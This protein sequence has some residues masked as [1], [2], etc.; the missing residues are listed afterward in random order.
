MCMYQNQNRLKEMVY[1]WP[2]IHHVIISAQYI[3]LCLLFLNTMI[4]TDKLGSPWSKHDWDWQSDNMLPTLYNPI[5][6]NSCNK[7]MKPLCYWPLYVCYEILLGA[8]PR[9]SL[10]HVEASYRKGSLECEV[11]PSKDCSLTQILL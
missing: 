2:I 8:V 9:K 10:M 4:V 3:S 1:C 7:L 6:C 11:I 5:S